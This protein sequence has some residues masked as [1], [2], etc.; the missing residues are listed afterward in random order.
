MQTTTSTVLH[1]LY[2]A[3]QAADEAYEW[4]IMNQFGPFANRF[5]YFHFEHNDATKLARAAK[6]A[7]DK[8]WHHFLKS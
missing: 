6:I 1:P 3:A 2:L 7:A 4:A 5:D 8:A